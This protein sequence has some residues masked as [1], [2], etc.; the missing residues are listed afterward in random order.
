MD[1]ETFKYEDLLCIYSVYQNCQDK[2]DEG[3]QNNYGRYSRT[4][5]DIN[6][7]SGLGIANILL[8]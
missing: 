4:Q 3:N 8:E 6:I 7:K 5:K 2:V 1:T